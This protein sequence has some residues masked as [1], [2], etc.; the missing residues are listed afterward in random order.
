[1]A[2]APPMPLE[3]AQARLLEMAAPLSTE[4]VDIEGAGA[5]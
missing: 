4:H 5:R 2:K 3:E 1:M